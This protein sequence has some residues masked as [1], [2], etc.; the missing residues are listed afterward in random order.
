M[1]TA[2]ITGVGGQDGSYLSELLLSKG[3]VVHGL[4]RPCSNDNDYRIRHLRDHENFYVHKG[5]V[6][7]S[8]S[9]IVK[10]VD[11][12]EIYNLASLSDVDFSFDQPKC[13]MET[14]AMGTLELL[15]TI[16]NNNSSQK[17]IK[18]FQACGNEIFGDCCD[19]EE[20][21]RPQTETTIPNPKSP[22][23]VSRLCS[24]WLVKTYRKAHGMFAVNGIMFDHESP[25]KNVESSIVRKVCRGV[26]DIH[27][28]FKKFITIGDLDTIRDWGHARDYAEAM[29]KTLQRKVPDDYVICTGVPRRPRD[30]IEKAFEY[31]D[32]FIEWKGKGFEEVGIDQHGEMR[33]KVDPDCLDERKMNH[34]LGSFDKIRK[35]LDWNPCVDFDSLVDEI[36][37]VE[38]M[39]NE[40]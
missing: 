32:V 29:W 7:H 30:L 12:D 19:D 28:G 10:A 13:F 15:E 6:S 21:L 36:M 37:A 39:I 16:R 38:M 22:H 25:R 8:I 14:N 4:L 18:F 35:E 40:E 31:V 17:I 20:N 26:V 5:D 24:Y 34:S 1:S 9:N 27:D 11:P 23:G 3:Y 2:L 33:V